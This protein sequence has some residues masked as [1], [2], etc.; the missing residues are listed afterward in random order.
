MK[1]ALV[2][3]GKMGLLHMGILNTMDEIQITAIAEKENLLA[4]YIK[5]TLPSIHIYDDYEKML[6]VE[7][8]DVL[9]ITT[10]TPYHLKII[11]SCVK[12][13]INFFVEKPLTKNLKEAQTICS[14]LKD[15]KINHAVGYNVRFVDTF[16]KGKSL[17]DSE[18]LGEVKNVKSSMYVSNIFSKPSGWR[19]KKKLS[20][21]GVLVEFGCHLIDLNS[22]YFGNVEKLKAET[23]SVYSDVDDFANVEM[24]FSSGISGNI[25]TSW[26]KKGYRIAEIKME[27]TGNN[28]KMEI[29]QDYID[30]KLKKLIS[31][32]T[33]LE[34]RIYKQALEG[35]VYFDVGGPEY[36]KQ[37]E[38]VI[39]CFKL[40]KQ[41]LVN[42]IE[43]SKTQSII[44][45]AY[46]SSESNNNF[47]KVDYL[48]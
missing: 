14:N 27:I 9:F 46:D 1:A 36:T 39:E 28:G 20:G 5:N 6:D 11:Q 16:A 40:N 30:I 48:E 44:Q 8:L 47:V 37:D 33:K 24:E 26:S 42:I 17:L 35:N 22:W 32:L 21:G 45:A 31:P 23:K 7:D 34:S 41:P 38:H 19:F 10:P 4:K 29:N 12:R 15:S 3:L 13:G 43:A 25:D 2:G 18:I